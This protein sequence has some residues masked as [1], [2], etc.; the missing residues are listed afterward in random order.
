MYSSLPKRIYNINPL[1]KNISNPEV[2]ELY[3]VDRCPAWRCQPTVVGKLTFIHPHI[4]WHG[5]LPRACFFHVYTFA[6]EYSHR[7]TSALSVSGRYNITLQLITAATKRYYYYYYY[8]YSKSSGNRLYLFNL[9]NK[10]WI[11][12][13]KRGKLPLLPANHAVTSNFTPMED[14]LKEWCNNSVMYIVYGRSQWPC[15][16]RRGSTALPFWDCGF[17]SLRGYGCL[18][19]VSGIFRWVEVSASGR[20]LFQGVLA[21]VVCLSVIE[22]PQRRVLGPLEL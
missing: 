20:S 1:R 14:C 22:K 17:E 2:S 13:L 5:M 16:L 9:L 21:S 8:Y 4:L 18:Y 12:I 19:L 6:S 7:A 10:T 3:S 11:Q 15:G